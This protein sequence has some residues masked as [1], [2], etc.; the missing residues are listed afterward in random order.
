[1]DDT[2]RSVLLSLKN[3]RQ[4]K[5]LQERDQQQ[6]VNPDRD[7]PEE[8]KYVPPQVKVYPDEEQEPN[9]TRND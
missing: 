7:R 4:I 8:E 3:R 5:D 1:M 6:V 2:N 9:F